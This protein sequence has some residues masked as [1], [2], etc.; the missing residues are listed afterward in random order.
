MFE[1]NRKTL[2][3]KL[4]NDVLSE[5]N[6]FS[7]PV[8]LDSIFEKFNIKANYTELNSISGFAAIKPNEQKQVFINSKE[9]PV[10]QRFTAAHELGHL[11]LHDEEGVSVD[12]TETIYHFRSSNMP[13]GNQLK[14]TE[15]NYFA[16]CL[17][18]PA[19]FIEKK[20]QEL[21]SV[22][23]D[24][25]ETLDLLAKGFNVSK[26]AFCTRLGSLGYL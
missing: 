25:E 23:F 14:E 4:A 22:R 9:S 11:F 15:A 24:D 12:T 26:I 5:S 18:M 21:Q 7:C 3:E 10:R 19:S 2:I 20:F 1:K 13:F 6:N 8:N 16:A 17:L